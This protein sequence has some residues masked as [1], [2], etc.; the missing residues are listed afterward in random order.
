LDNKFDLKRSLENITLEGAFAMVFIVLTGGAFLIGFALLLG[1]NDFEIGL[2]AAIPFLAQAA[3]LVAA[4]LV[5]LTGKRKLITIQ[6]IFVARQIWWLLI[7]LP[8]LSGAW[9]LYFLLIVF[10]ISSSAAMMANAGW[11]SWMAEL[12][13]GRIRGRYFGFR[14][15]VLA[16]ST[17]IATLVGGA[18]LDH[19]K[20]RNLEGQGFA[21]IIAISCLFAFI[22]LLLLKKFP[23]RPMPPARAHWTYL[24]EPLKNSGFKHLIKVF[25]F[26]NFSLGI[27]AAFFAAHML[28]NLKMSFTQISLYASAASIAAILLNK[29]WG[30]IVDRFGSKPVIVVCAFGLALVPMIWWIPRQGHLEIL[31]FEAAYSGA[32]W[33]GFNLAAFNIPIANSPKVGRTTYLAMFSV[34][35]GLGFFIASILGGFLAENWKNIHYQLGFQTIVNYHILFAIS[36]TLRLLAAFL[37]LGFHEPTEKDVP[38]MIQYMGGSVIRQFSGWNRLFYGFSKP[39][40]FKKLRKSKIKRENTSKNDLLK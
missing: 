29:P 3:Q 33:T 27:S 15:A 32:L 25:T 30:I 17:I 19:F 23:D 1:A 36:T 2:L 7:P 39:I 31:I 18:V 10:G 37:A 35:T 20:T 6:S 9:R 8:F 40:R 4:Y 11:M 21:I 26:W 38:S 24:L 14:S 28:T 12:V 13:P 34:I 5:D 22:A 16:I